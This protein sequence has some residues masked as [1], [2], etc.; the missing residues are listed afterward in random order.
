MTVKTAKVLSIDVGQEEPYI[1]TYDASVPCEQC[2]KENGSSDRLFGS[3]CNPNESVE[4]GVEHVGLCLKH[5]GEAT[6]LDKK[7]VITVEE[8]FPR[9]KVYDKHMMEEPAIERFSV[10]TECEMCAS[11]GNHYR[12]SY[13]LEN[14][15]LV[16]LCLEHLKENYHGFVEEMKN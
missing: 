9:L 7:A 1:V 12:G 6:W 5:Y 10:K 8:W 16:G 13:V 11:Q 3:Y 14:D 15:P 2:F 4:E